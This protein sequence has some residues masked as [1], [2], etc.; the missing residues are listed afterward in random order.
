MYISVAQATDQ[1]FQAADATESLVPIKY[2]KLRCA[3]SATDEIVSMVRNSA[4][5]LDAA[6]ERLEQKYAEDH[7]IDSQELKCF[8]DGCRYYCTGNLAWRYV[9]ILSLD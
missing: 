7:T 4:K 3:Q 2:A 9:W 8:I 1:F 5:D 6:A